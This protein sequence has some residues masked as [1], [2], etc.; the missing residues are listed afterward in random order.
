MGRK[1]ALW[2]GLLVA[3]ALLATAGCRR[4]ATSESQGA[5]TS[6][7]DWKGFVDG[8]FDAYYEANPQF[9]ADQG[10]HQYDGRFPDWSASGIKGWIA[11]LHGF[12]DRA[13]AFSD[14]ALNDQQRLDRDNLLARIDNDLF[15]LEDAR[16]L[17]RNP[18]AYSFSPSMYLTRD[19]AP[20][21]E[22]MRAYTTFASNMPQAVDH[23]L[24]NLQTPLPRTYVALGELITGGLA[25]F[26]QS[27]VPGI[28]SSVTDEDAQSAFR[29]ANAAG[30]AAMEKAKEWFHAQ[31]DEANDDYRLGPELFQKMLWATERVDTP[32]ADLKSIGERDLERNMTALAEAC[33]AFAPGAS[34]ADCVAREK[35]DKPKGDPVDAARDQLAM[36][37]QFIVDHHVVTIPGTEE[38]LVAEAPPFNRWNFAYIEIP[39]PFEKDLPSIYYI[40]PPDPSWSKADQQQYLPGKADLLFVSVHEVWPGHFLQFLHANRAKSKIGKSFVGYAYA[41]GWAHYAEEMMWEEGLGNGDPETHIGQLTN[42]LL[43]DVRFLSAIGLHTGDMTVAESEKMFEEK[44]F[45]DPGNARQQ[46]AR[47]TFDPAYLNY[48]MGKLMIRKLRKDWTADHGGRDGWQAFHDQFLSYGGP[49]IPLVRKAMVGDGGSLF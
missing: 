45:Q 43:R 41:E 22:R 11:R 46:A 23:M 33:S 1:R 17:E 34:L 48:T 19:Y 14:A 7:A 13:A 40:A 24:T 10:L 37:R 2:V 8:F 5:S 47:G 39:G 15:W 38:A 25:D 3:L 18:A 12:R 31:A 9:A 4:S 6:G 29:Q 20:L 42:A 28:F 26:M 27:D 21:E 35:A 44:G 36:L 49:P 16:S 32:V 30:V